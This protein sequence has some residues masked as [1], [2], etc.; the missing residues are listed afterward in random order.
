MNELNWRE[1]L[2]EVML[3]LIFSHAAEAGRAQADSFKDIDILNAIGSAGSTSASLS[4]SA[5]ATRRTLS[6]IT[7]D[8]HPRFEGVERFTWTQPL[9]STGKELRDHLVRSGTLPHE[10]MQFRFVDK[11]G[12]KV[13]LNFSA[14]L[15]DYRSQ[16]RYDR[17]HRVRLIVYPAEGLVRSIT[18]E[19][20][21]P[22]VQEPR[23]GRRA[24]NLDPLEGLT[25]QESL[26][27]NEKIKEMRGQYEFQANICFPGGREPIAHSWH[28][29]KQQTIGEMVEC[30]VEDNLFPEGQYVVTYKRGHEYLPIHSSYEVLDQLARHHNTLYIRGGPLFH[31]VR[32]RP[33][34]LKR[35]LGF[36][37]R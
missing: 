32:R 17:T 33:S 27:L 37:R 10:K 18:E 35:F 22:S 19:P 24:S 34:L 3:L 4:P 8:V 11:Y 20:K 7:F 36:M 6:Q 15:S 9:S 31:D 14:R 29:S 1:W 16:F 30:F 26:V 28:G 13:P 12:D 25:W 2:L 23:S 5:S 21:R